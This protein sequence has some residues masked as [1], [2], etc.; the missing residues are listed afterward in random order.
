M[1]ELEGAIMLAALCAQFDIA[2]APGQVKAHGVCDVFI[3]TSRLLEVAYPATHSRT[4]LGNDPL[5][6]EVTIL[7]ESHVYT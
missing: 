2:L 3:V 7:A 6:D 4:R 5:S 1:A